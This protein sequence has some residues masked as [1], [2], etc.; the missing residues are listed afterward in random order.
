MKTQNINLLSI[1]I[2]DSMIT[3]RKVSKRFGSFEAIKS[4]SLNIRAGEIHG[5]V[6]ASGAGKSTLL[7]MM[8]LLEMPDKGDV[9]VDGKKLNELNGKQ[10]RHIR[11]SLG[12]IFQGYHLVGNK[13]VFDNVAVPL[14]IAKVAKR[15]RTER[16]LE[17]LRFVG[18]ETYKD[19][20]PGQLS[21]GQKQRV[22]I[23]RAIV[24]SPKVL[25]CD[26]PTSA[27]DPATTMEVLEVLKRINEQ[28]NVTVVIVSHEMEVIK[29]LCER[30]TVIA[31]GQI[32][33]DFSIEPT[34]VH[35]LEQGAAVF[36]EQLKSGGGGNSSGSIS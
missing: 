2:G 29:S 19:Q 20:Y 14:E 16:V 32:Y 30:V 12:M 15:K 1:K 33:D 11:Q 4:V 8:N 10:I 36:V 31:E 27:L 28:F 6:G 22:A 17:S 26:E 34:G 23:A 25:L 5:I 24:N 7:R 18:L 3:L 9:I 21:G 13:T 35:K